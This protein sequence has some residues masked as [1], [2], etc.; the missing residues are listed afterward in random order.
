MVGRKID[1][2]DEIVTRWNVATYEISDGF[3]TT[4][5]FRHIGNTATSC[6]KVALLTVN[7]TVQTK[8][9]GIAKFSLS[10]YICDLVPGP[11]SRAMFH[12]PLNLQAT[13]R[14]DQPVFFNGKASIDTNGT[15]VTLKIQSNDNNGNGVAN[16]DFYWQLK[17]YYSEVVS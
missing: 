1:F 4:R 10:D 15:D 6:H 9:N 12:G 13:P 8:D 11:G 5:E 7:G 2:P 14:S 16:I 17:C 3:V